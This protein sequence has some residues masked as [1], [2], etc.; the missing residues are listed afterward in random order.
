M[1]G[2]GV[3][4]GGIAVNVL[5]VT[6]NEGVE[7]LGAAEDADGK[8][9]SFSHTD[10]INKVLNTVNDNNKRDLSASFYG[11]TDSEKAEMK[12]KAKTNV[13]AGTTLQGTGVHTYVQ[14]SSTLE[15]E[16]EP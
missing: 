4:A 12:E 14:N 15:A 10:T 9:T 3:G 8:A 16:K 1:V 11:M 7:K 5:A 2:V 6:V 13:K